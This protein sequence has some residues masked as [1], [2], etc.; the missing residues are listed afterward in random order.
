M[1]LSAWVVQ[2]GPWNG[3]GLS[4]VSSVGHCDQATSPDTPCVRR[5]NR[6]SLS[7]GRS[8][9]IVQCFSAARGLA[10]TR[11]RN[12]APPDLSLPGPSVIARRRDDAGCYLAVDKDFWTGTA[13]PR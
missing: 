5:G 12:V 7:R 4:P 9:W 8:S 3:V 11:G 10:S 1:D 6:I 2:G 13:P